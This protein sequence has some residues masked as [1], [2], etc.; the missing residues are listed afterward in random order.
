M[1]LSSSIR[2]GTS[3]S[4][5][6]TTDDSACRKIGDPGARVGRKSAIVV[7]NDEPLILKSQLQ[8]LLFEHLAKL[9]AQ[10]RQQHFA[11][12]AF[13]RR[14]PVDVEVLGEGRS[15]PVFQHV[16]PPAI[17]RIVDAHVIGHDV[18]EQAQL[19]IAQRSAARPETAIRSPSAGSSMA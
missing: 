9:I 12:Q 7:T 17:V 1:M 5:C 4:S 8:L 3:A 14:V 19:V 11:A 18:D 2:S 6:S 13:L 15:R 10:H 16:L